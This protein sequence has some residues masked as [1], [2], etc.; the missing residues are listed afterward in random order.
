MKAWKDIESAPTGVVCLTNEG[1]TIC[2]SKGLW[3]TCDSDGNIPWCA[4]E[5]IN[6]SLAQPTKWLATMDEFFA[7]PTEK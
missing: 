2:S 5:G 4:E 1:T 3:Y 6:T 7:L